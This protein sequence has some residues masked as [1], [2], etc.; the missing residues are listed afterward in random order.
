MRELE[1]QVHTHSPQ[2][3][4]DAVDAGSILSPATD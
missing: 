2:W 1:F 3:R 4:S